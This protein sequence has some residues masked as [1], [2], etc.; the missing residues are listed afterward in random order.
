MIYLVYIY[1]FGQFTYGYIFQQTGIVNQGLEAIGLKPV[2]WLGDL[3]GAWVAITICTV[4]WT[5][6]FNTI[7]LL[8]A[9]QEIPKSLYEAAS[10]D[11]AMRVASAS[12]RGP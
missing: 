8:T 3:P 7:I 5:I 6:G 10:L 2:N 4:W 9:L 12:S 11:G 1:I